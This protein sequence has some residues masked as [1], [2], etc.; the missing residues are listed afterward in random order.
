LLKTIVNFIKPV[1]ERFPRLA[2]IYRSIR[3]SWDSGCE[4][5]D[6]PMGFKLVGNPMMEKGCFEPLE[7]EWVRRIVK[8]VE[9]FINIGA[10]IGYYCCLTLA[11]RG[12]DFS[13]VAFEPIA[14]NI[15]YLK[16]NISANSFDENV[17]LFPMA[18]SDKPGLMKMYGGGVCA[19]LVEG[20][21]GINSLHYT[22]VPVNTL[23]NVLGGR[24]ERKQCFILVDI[25]GAEYSMLKGASCF[26][27]RDPK[28]V[29]LVEVCVNEH[30]PDGVKTNPDLLAV[31]ETYWTAGYEAWTVNYNPRRVGREEICD[32]AAS[33][34][35]TL[36]THNFVFADKQWC[37]K[38]FAEYV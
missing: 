23:D 3:D 15:D 28:P 38:F 37:D 1:V 16:K 33:G 11:E 12:D 10:N 32:I 20:W 24:F 30:Q 29:W 8:D 21:E 14:S 19:S 26:I 36:G 25:E 35:D 7:S 18:L 27:T 13:V 9:V 17:E 31:L 22:H 2:I 4:P 34:I 5:R 6:T